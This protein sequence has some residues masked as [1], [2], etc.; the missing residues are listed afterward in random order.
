MEKL[1]TKWVT[2]GNG[3]TIDRLYGAF[4]RIDPTDPDL[5]FLNRFSEPH[6]GQEKT[7]LKL[8]G[9]LISDYDWLRFESAAFKVGK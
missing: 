8:T 3:D 7:N 2:P 5:R 6:S 9:E 1:G 4:V